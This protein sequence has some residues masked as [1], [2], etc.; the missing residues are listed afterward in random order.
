M[1][2]T[3]LLSDTEEGI[4]ILDTIFGIILFRKLSKELR[5]IFYFTAFGAFTEI[6]IDFYKVHIDRVTMP[7]GHFY[8]T[9]S[10]IILVIFYRKVLEGFVRKGVIAFFGILYTIYAVINPIFIQSLKEFPNILGASGAIMIVIFSLLLFVKIMAEARIEKLG[11][12]PIV[13]I[14]SAILLY[15]AG[16][17]FYYMLININVK[18]FIAFAKHTVNFYNILNIVLYVLIGGSFLLTWRNQK[19]LQRT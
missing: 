11:R 14:N 7:I 5:I 18:Y 6:F 4:A 13:W 10:I 19:H 16:N 2:L 3:R 8:L 12:E 17:F 1:S 15:Y 9:F